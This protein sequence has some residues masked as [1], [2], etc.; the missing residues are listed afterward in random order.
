[1]PIVAGNIVEST[2][3]LRPDADFFVAI[4]RSRGKNA[5]LQP[6]EPLLEAAKRLR[7]VAVDLVKRSPNFTSSLVRCAGLIVKHEDT[8]RNGSR[9][10]FVMR[11]R[12]DTAYL[13]RFPPLSEWP[14]PTVPTLFSDYLGN[15]SRCDATPPL[16]ARPYASCASCPSA[17]GVS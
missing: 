10:T 15:G 16:S 6:A 9:Y 1:M 3:R 5:L 12:P 8:A 11:L 2:S 13:R 7:P 17:A 14:R 4:D